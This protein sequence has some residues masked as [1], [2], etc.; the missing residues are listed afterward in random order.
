MNILGNDL[1]ISMPHLMP[2]PQ[3]LTGLGRG[4]TTENRYASTRSTDKSV[5]VPE[6]AEAA[7]IWVMRYNDLDGDARTA[8]DSKIGFDSQE[9]TGY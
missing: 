6:A 3:D 8:V 5:H 9:W 1:D 7:K 4:S 2:F